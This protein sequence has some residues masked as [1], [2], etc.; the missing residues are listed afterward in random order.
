M[1]F[2]KDFLVVIPDDID[3][4]HPLNG[5]DNLVRKGAI[6][7]GIAEVQ[8]GLNGM[9]GA[10]VS[11]DSLKRGEVAVNICNEWIFIGLLVE[12]SR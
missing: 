5:L 3:K 6:A 7:N 10:G 4:S 2:I 12:I 1:R 11:Q 8:D 9:P